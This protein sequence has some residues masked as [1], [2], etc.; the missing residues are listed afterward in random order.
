MATQD[1][2]NRTWTI[3]AG[4]FGASAVLLGAFGAHAL[5]SRVTPA[6]L[7]TWRTA[8]DFH[9][10]H[11]VALLA[12]ALRP[13]NSHLYRWCRVLFASGIALFSGSLYAMVLSGARQL[14][15]I[16]PFG[17]LCFTAGWLSLVWVASKR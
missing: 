2:E 10:L 16:T 7:G 17:G 13:N 15:I 9:L 3:A 8:V 12:L 5:R 1:V 14:G 6:E 11:A 4:L